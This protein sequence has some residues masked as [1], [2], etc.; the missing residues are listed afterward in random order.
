MYISICLYEYINVHIHAYTYIHIYIYIYIGI[1]MY[2]HYM[3][4]YICIYIYIC[5]YMYIYVYICIYMYIYMYIYVYIYTYIHINIYIYS[6]HNANTHM[7][8]YIYIYTCVYIYIYVCEYAL[9]FIPPSL[10][11]P[12]SLLTLNKLPMRWGVET[13]VWKHESLER[14]SGCGKLDRTCNRDEENHQEGGKHAAS[15][16]SSLS[17]PCELPTELKS[18]ARKSRNSS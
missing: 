10:P 12:P 18:R 5:I 11:L 17:D 13:R 6:R 3:C 9:C 7:Y 1:H 8:I 16:D 15:K 14:A 4:V 2:I